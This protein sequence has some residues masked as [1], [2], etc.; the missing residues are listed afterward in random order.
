[1]KG[2][3]ICVSMIPWIPTSFAHYLTPRMPDDVRCSFIPFTAAFFPLSLRYLKKL[4][5]RYVDIRARL[6]AR[7]EEHGGGLLEFVAAQTDVN[8]L[9]GN[10]LPG[11]RKEL[12]VR[13]LVV[14]SES[15]CAYSGVRR[16]RIRPFYTAPVTFR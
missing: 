12:R 2:F 14:V 7:V 9:F 3:G 10:P 1:M 8:Q 15:A 5:P 4:T 16:A 13:Y 11:K 6:Q